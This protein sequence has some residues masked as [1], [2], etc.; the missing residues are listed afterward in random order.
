MGRAKQVVNV[1]ATPSGKDIVTPIVFDDQ[2]RQTRNYLPVP[3][4]STSNGAIYSQ[5][6]GMVSYPVADV[7]NIYSGKRLTLKPFWK[8]LHCRGFCSK[9]RLEMTGIPNL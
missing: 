7:T 1:K 5:T 2:G 6:P 4:S 8:T 3:Q 9:N